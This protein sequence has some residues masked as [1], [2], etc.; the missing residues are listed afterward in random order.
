MCPCSIYESILLF[1]TTVWISVLL[2]FLVLGPLPPLP[3]MR[4][5][6]SHLWNIN[7]SSSF[8][9]FLQVFPIPSQTA[10]LSPPAP[11]SSIRAYPLALATGPFPAPRQVLRKA[12][13][14]ILLPPFL[15]P[16]LTRSSPPLD[17]TGTLETRHLFLFNLTLT[18]RV[19]G[20]FFPLIPAPLFCS[21]L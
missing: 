19:I 20:A 14:P 21:A 10:R 5:F 6:V 1:R 4:P 15:P 17:S 8:S 2:V 12:I 13:S 16:S 3:S 11:A 9:H 18:P 7:W